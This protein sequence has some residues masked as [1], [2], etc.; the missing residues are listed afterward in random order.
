MIA[1]SAKLYRESTVSN[2]CIGEEVTIGDFTRVRNSH[3]EDFCYIDRQNLLLGV[4]MG[5]RSY[6][7]PWDMIFKCIIGS[8]CSISYGVTIGAPEHD[9]SRASTHQFIYDPKYRLF[10][11]DQDLR[12]EKFSQ[13]VEI[14]ND[15]WIGCNSTILRGVTIGDGAVIAANAVVT[16]DVPPYAIVAGVPARVIKYRFSN[17]II[18]RLLMIKWWNWSD[19]KIKA[20]HAFFTKT[21]L[22]M[23]DFNSIIEQ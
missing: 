3:V 23:T 19:S 2:S 9:Y 6:T 12:N 11:E 17:E 1:S 7:G 13:P 15:V 4:T 18:N 16:K 22:E 10:D 14:G 20:N 8:Y 5:K 21:K